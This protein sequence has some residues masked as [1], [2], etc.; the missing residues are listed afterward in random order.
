MA[1]RAADFGVVIDGAVSVDMKRVK[2]RK[3]QVSG[4]SN[5]GVEVGLKGMTNCTVYEGHARF[6]S[7]HEVSVGDDRLSA[8]RILINVGCRAIV[9]PLPGLDQV[10]YLTNSSMMDVDFLPGHLVIVG[11]GYVGAV[12][13]HPTVSE[14][15]PT[16]LGELKPLVA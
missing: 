16:M 3:D 10:P 2:Q 4:E 1:R 9:P 15:I 14:L 7:P 6:E 13:I 5:S 11:G 8:R 12:H